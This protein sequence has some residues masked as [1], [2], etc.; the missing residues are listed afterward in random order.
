MSNPVASELFSLFSFH[1]IIGVYTPEAI[2][3]LTYWRICS[4]IRRYDPNTAQ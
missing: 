1:D 2:L 3:L 4:E